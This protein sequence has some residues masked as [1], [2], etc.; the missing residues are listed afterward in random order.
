MDKSVLRRDLPRIHELLNKRG[1][2]FTL[3]VGPLI[4]PDRL[5]ADTDVA[6]AAVKAYVETVLPRDPERP[7]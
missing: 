6:T 3:T 4:P 5:D 1:G 7:F 2:R